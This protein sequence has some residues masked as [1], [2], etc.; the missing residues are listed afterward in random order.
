MDV[1]ARP[2]GQ[3]I[4]DQ[5]RLVRGVIVPDEMNLKSLGDVGLDLVEEL[6]ELGRPMTAIA[7]SNHVAGCDVEG[8]NSEVVPWRL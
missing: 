6:S 2:L 8:S 7:L 4:A 5:R 3:P 1:P